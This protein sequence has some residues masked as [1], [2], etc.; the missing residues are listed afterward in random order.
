MVWR[1]ILAC[2]DSSLLHCFC[3]TTAWNN[4][5]SELSLIINLLNADNDHPE[6]VTTATA[7]KTMAKTA[8]KTLEVISTSSSQC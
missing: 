6:N 2:S 1:K 3:N 8:K 5:C 7:T 4:F